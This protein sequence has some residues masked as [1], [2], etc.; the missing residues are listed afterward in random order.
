MKILFLNTA[1]PPLI[2]G[3]DAAL[4][5]TEL[6]MRVFGGTALTIFPLA[7][8]SRFF[9]RW[10][11]GFH[12]LADI[13]RREK[14]PL[15]YH[16]SYAT[17]YP[18]PVLAFLRRP[19]VYS[20]IAGLGRTTPPPAWLLR[21][22]HT[23]VVTHARDAQRL[24]EWGIHQAKVIPPGIDTTR[25]N[26]VPPPPPLDPKTPLTLLVGS[27]PWTRAQ[28]ETKG[29]FALLD[30]VSRGAPVRLVFL[31]RGLFLEELR[32]AIRLFG[33]ENRVE[34]VTGHAD[35]AKLLKKCHA[36]V[37]LAAHDRLVKAFPHSLIESLAAGRPI[38]ISKTLAMADYV[39]EKGNGVVVD[40][41]TPQ[42]LDQS[43]A[44]L[45][46]D[47]PRLQQS[48]MLNARRDFTR[49]T[50]LKAYAEVFRKAGT[51]QG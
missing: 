10:L 42:S 23:V 5:D 36:A 37:V 47:Y 40:T 26:A 50:M 7:W 6:F 44:R 13:L 8:P 30:A 16:L 1:P 45:I 11:Y 38:L 20:V 39:M 21:R 48:A 3:T 9:P 33:V 46:D 34:I 32:S 22:V 43:I 4:Q 24:Q 25:F 14:A 17:L 18:F 28:F 35:V 49:E 27:A 12:V 29:I 15:V 2:P 41:L 31:W 51:T 19:V